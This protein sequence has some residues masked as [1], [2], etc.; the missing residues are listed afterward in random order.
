[1]CEERC[2]EA[3][4][5]DETRDS[6][7]DDEA[8]QRDREAH[9]DGEESAEPVAGG[10]GDL[11]AALE[12]EDVQQQE[13]EQP[14]Q[15]ELLTQGREDEVGVRV[16]DHMRSPFAESVADE[17]AVG[18][19]EQSL[20]QL[21]G[22]AG[23]LVVLL[24]REGVQPAVDA[25]LDVGEDLGG[26]QRTCGEHAEAQE[27]PGLLRGGDV[28]HRD[29]QPEVQQRRAEIALEDEDADARHPC[30]EDGA[31]VAQARELQAQELRTGQHHL[32]AVR[33]EVA[34][35]EDR[36]QDLR[37]LTGLE[38]HRTDEDPDAGAVDR[39]AQPR[40][41]GQE[42]EHERGEAGRVRV[43]AQ[44]PVV[45]QEHDDERGQHGAQ[46]HPDELGGRS[47][48]LQC[49]VDPIDHREPDP[50]EEDCDGDE[51]G[52]RVGRAPPH[53][54]VEGHAEHSEPDRVRVD[55]RGD[56]VSGAHSDERVGARGYD[57]REE[58]QQEF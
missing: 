44:Q 6:A 1:M 10:G 29:E 3:G 58:D 56:L 33:D 43:A 50:V 12:E 19:S 34:G 14:D 21:V 39:A 18:H 30:D 28:E 26:D 52:V 37:D 48:A 41:E 16:G 23:G 2:G 25:L 17:P 42:Q 32:V 35:E 24:R 22:A 11:H 51:H 20:H 53:D 40:D 15:A 49:H 13:G 55:V 46:G 54:D 27:D 4:E 45:A 7:D 57:Y 47:T 9:S 36:Q 38:R 8:L 31:H 5:R